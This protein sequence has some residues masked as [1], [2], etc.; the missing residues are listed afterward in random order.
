MQDFLCNQIKSR[1]GGKAEMLL[2]DTDSLMYKIETENV[3]EHL[4]KK[5]ELFD[6]SH[7]SKDSNYYEKSNDL[8]VGKI[9]VGK[10]KDET[11]GVPIQCLKD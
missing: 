9:V 3:C 2:T 11:C 5:K 8:V 1:Y 6:L 4:R 10:M 7:Y